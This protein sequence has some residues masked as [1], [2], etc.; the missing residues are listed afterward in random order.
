[1]CHSHSGVVSLV[2]WILAVIK[3]RLDY[4]ITCEKCQP[5]KCQ[6]YAEV[7]RAIDTEKPEGGGSDAGYVAVKIERED[8]TSTRERRALQDLQG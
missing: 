4:K 6:P 2:T 5:Y 7:Y 8:K 1:V 3:C